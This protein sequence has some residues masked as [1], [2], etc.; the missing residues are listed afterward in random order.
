[1]HFTFQYGF[2]TNVPS[3]YHPHD[4]QHLH[5][6]QFF[7]EEQRRWRELWYR[8]LCRQA[9]M[10]AVASA[11][12]K[13]DVQRHYRLPSGKVRVVPLAPPTAEYG[14]PTEA[15]TVEV[16]AR[17][18][19]PGSYLLYPAQTWPHKNHIA[20]VNVLADLRHREGLII[21]LVAPGRQN[22]FFP[23]IAQHI[24]A[25]G[26]EDQVLWPGFVAPRDLQVLY[27][28]A[29]GVVIPSKFEAASGPLWEA[30]LAGIP[31]ACSNVTSLPAQA[32]DAALIFD[33]DQPEQILSAVR[34]LWVDDSLRAKLMVAGKQRVS[35]FTWE[36]TA[37]MFRAHYRRLAGRQLAEEDAVLVAA[38]PAL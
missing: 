26:I 36:K 20:L 18:S 28:K 6:P 7:S 30:F 22:E 11:W 14:E 12:T 2:R 27:R 29:R 38:K 21:P 16:A 10:V 37:R 1:M 35:A 17:L 33:P 24:R 19:L 13:N 25:M 34:R 32:G 31:V 4:L 8:T 15:E 9:A 3:I 5:L 23:A